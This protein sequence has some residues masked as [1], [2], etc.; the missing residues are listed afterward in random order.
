MSFVCLVL[1]WFFFFSKFS[2]TN[3]G[4]GSLSFG[5]TLHWGQ[6][7]ESLLAFQRETQLDQRTGG[8]LLATTHL[9]PLQQHDKPGFCWSVA[10][11]Q[12]L[13]V[14][15]RLLYSWFLLSGCGQVISCVGNVMSP[16][17]KESSGIRIMV[18]S[19]VFKVP[20]CKRVLSVGIQRERRGRGSC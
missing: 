10:G 14:S 3:I 17:G 18:L 11:C 2:E 7:K 13:S 16:N 5:W 15:T 6:G 20:R 19:P 9:S 12:C 1:G 8:T 4:Q